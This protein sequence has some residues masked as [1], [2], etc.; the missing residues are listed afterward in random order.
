M[1]EHRRPEAD[2]VT[3]DDPAAVA[4][5]QRPHLGTQP[6]HLVHGDGAAQHQHRK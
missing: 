4:R 3:D 5:Q 6:G 2:R 1:P